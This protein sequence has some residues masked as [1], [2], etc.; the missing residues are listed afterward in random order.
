ML[1][2]NVS[3]TNLVTGQIL[4]Y[5]LGQQSLNQLAVLLNI[6]GSIRMLSQPCP[7]VQQIFA[8]YSC[9]TAAGGNGESSEL[10]CK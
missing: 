4:A 8:K 5:G 6:D 9:L 3:Y 2:H 10:S 7:Q 1:S